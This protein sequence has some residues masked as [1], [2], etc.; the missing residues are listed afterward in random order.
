MDAH[1]KVWRARVD[2]KTIGLAHSIGDA[3]G[4]QYE[5]RANVGN[6]Y[7]RDFAYRQVHF[8]RF[9]GSKNSALAQ[10][11]DDT[12]M[13]LT[14]LS[15]LAKNNYNYNVDDVI[16]S[17]MAWAN[18][19]PS[20][21]GKNTRELLCGVK[22][23][24]GYKSRFAKNHSPDI[25]SNGS[26]MRIWPVIFAKDVNQALEQ[27]CKITNDNPINI[28]CSYLYVK[29]LSDLYYS[30][31][32]ISDFSSATP[33]IGI[34][35][36]D[37]I[38]DASMGKIMRFFPDKTNG[39]VVHALYFAF[40]AALVNVSDPMVIYDLVIGRKIDPDTTGAIVGPVIACRFD[41]LKDNP[42]FQYLA[43]RV[44][45]CDTNSGDFPRDEKY[46]PRTYL[47]YV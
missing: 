34:A 37:A 16:L 9:N 20:G 7:V 36:S 19:K 44:C 26:L 39:W 27:D 13:S 47:S 17:Y 28:E 3:L 38:R 1:T 10:C 5:L 11:T 43:Q 29:L 24:S 6:H 31:F 23:I 42:S 35:I 15:S 22:T 46:H 25:Q 32:N 2:A 40:F 4:A 33:Q 30:R 41:G 21:M 12:E 14:L 18:S 8:N 45:E